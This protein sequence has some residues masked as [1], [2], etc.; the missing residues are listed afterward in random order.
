MAGGGN[1]NLG[2]NWNG[3]LVPGTLDTALFDNNATGTLTFSSAATTVAGVLFQNTSGELTLDPGARALN[4]TGNF[5]LGQAAGAASNVKLTSGSVTAALLVLG[6]NATANQNIATLDGAGVSFLANS[7]VRVGISGSDNRLSVLQGALSVGGDT[8]YVGQT[9]S[10]SRNKLEVIGAAATLNLTGAN[11]QVIIGSGANTG[12]SMEIAGGGKVES[13]KTGTAAV[14]VGYNGATQASLSVR[15]EESSLTSKGEVRIG[16]IATRSLLSISEGAKVESAAASLGLGAGNDN[17]VLID[18]LGSRWSVH[19]SDVNA[20]TA[21]FSV[22]GGATTGNRIVV[23]QQGELAITG[24]LAELVLGNAANSQKNELQVASGGRVSADRIVVGGAFSGAVNNKVILDGGTLQADVWISEGNGLEG[25]GTI[26][27]DLTQ[28][29]TLTP[30]GW[31]T[32]EGELTL[33]ETSSLF[34][35]LGSSAGESDRLVM[36]GAATFAGNLTLTL[37]GLVP[38]AGETFTLFS[39]A[40]ASGSF[41][42]LSLPTLEEGLFWNTGDLLVNGTLRVDAVPEPGSLM[43][44]AA[45]GSLWFAGMRWRRQRGA[46]A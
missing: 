24:T 31:L 29:G 11:G 28:G 7:S 39:F 1:F 34:L 22:Y 6:N 32:I 10:A 44:L 33:L 12:N 17:E 8:V 4:I 26:E 27:G 40:S 13:A 25:A 42:L 30:G 23:R 45:I 16:N 41:D 46:G 21:A 14:V 38:T 5:T 9:A 20:T 15:G 19:Q 2:T 36:T 37:D 3:D 18:G 43:L 35:E